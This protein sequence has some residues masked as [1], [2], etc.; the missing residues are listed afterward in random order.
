M[1][2]GFDGGGSEH[3]AIINSKG[4]TY[5][6]IQFLEI[7]RGNYYINYRTG[8]RV[9]DTHDQNVLVVKEAT[10]GD[11]PVLAYIDP[12][13]VLDDR[14]KMRRLAEQAGDNAKFSITDPNAFKQKIP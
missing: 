1:R 5:W 11:L 10:D 9:E 12:F 14:S 6:K 7:P 8:I 3:D 2:K 13:I 4:D